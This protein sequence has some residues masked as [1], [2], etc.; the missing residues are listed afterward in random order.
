MMYTNIRLGGRRTCFLMLLFCLVFGTAQ[1]DLPDPEIRPP[2]QPVIFLHGLGG[3]PFSW[4]FAATL[5]DAGGW[6][7]GGLL[8]TELETGSVA[9][10][11]PGDF[12]VVAFSDNQGLTLAQQGDELSRY[13]DA[14]LAANPAD[15]SVILVGHSMGAMASRAYLQ[16]FDAGNKVSQ[17]IAIGAPHGGSELTVFAQQSCSN[18]GVELVCELLEDFLGIDPFSVGVTELRPD[19][20]SLAALNDLQSNPL[21]TNTF[22]TSIVG[23]GT[24]VIGSNVDGDGVISGFYQNLGNVPGVELLDHYAIGIAVEDRSSCDPGFTPDPFFGTDINPL[25]NQTHTCETT[26]EDVLRAI[27]WT[28]LYGPPAATNL[29]LTSDPLLLGQSATF[30]VTGAE[31]GEQVLFAGSVSGAGENA[32]PCLPPEQGLVCLDIVDPVL[33]GQATAGVGGVASLTLP[34]NLQPGDVGLNIAMQAI[35]L[36]G[37]V[38]VKTQVVLETVSN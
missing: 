34:I 23:S 19:S 30:T 33:I 11:D 16:W 12:Y 17:L 4:L 20:Q 25:P 10:V 27:L 2:N 5:L 36:R 8:Q 21:P 6:S 29:V 15:S 24:P 1:A 9:P 32:G 28:I 37:A 38:P 26:D 18:G 14:V 22:Y 35:I 31:L 13:V 3:D 7:F